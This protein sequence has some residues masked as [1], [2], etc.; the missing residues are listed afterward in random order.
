[1][2]GRAGGIVQ[3]VEHLPSK[4]KGLLSSNSS[5]TKR[6]TEERRGEK[7]GD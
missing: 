2:W 7:K 6:K 4:H 5:T 3:I 1:V